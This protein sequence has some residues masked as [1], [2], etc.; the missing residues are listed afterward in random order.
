[1]SDDVPPSPLRHRALLGALGAVPLG[2]AGV[3]ATDGTASAAAEQSRHDRIPPDTRPGGA[4]DRYVAKLAGR[5]GMTG[6]AYY[7]RPRWL[8]DEHIAHSYM[9]QADGSRVDTVR[10][11]DKDSPGPGMAGQNNARNFVPD[12]GF[13]TA[14]DLVRFAEALDDGTM[15]DSAWADVFTSVK[16][17]NFYDDIPLREIIGQQRQAVTGATLDPPG[18]D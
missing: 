11:L 14:P 3:L 5:C 18:G 10:N 1:M 12:G 13:V 9:R 16:A 17:P 7:T 15:L 8:T 2:A 6:S 4:Y